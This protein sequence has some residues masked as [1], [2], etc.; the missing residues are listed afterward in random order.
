M[1]NFDLLES[2]G[3]S[4]KTYCYHDGPDD[5]LLYVVDQADLRAARRTFYFLYL[6]GAGLLSASARRQWRGR[7]TDAGRSSTGARGC[8]RSR[9]RPFGAAV[10]TSSAITTARHRGDG[11]IQARRRCA[12]PIRAADY[13]CLLDSTMARFWFTFARARESVTKA[14]KEGRCGRW[15]H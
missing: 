2:N 9:W 12:L 4:Y 3:T 7:G 13:L 6:A 5:E 15:Q 11:D 10:F 14:L 8:T 1:L